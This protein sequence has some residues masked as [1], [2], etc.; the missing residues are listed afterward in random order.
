MRKRY[1]HS[2]FPICSHLSIKRGIYH[3]RRILPV[4]NT[5]LTISL[6]TSNYRDARYT[7]SVLDRKY[8]RILQTHVHMAD[9][10]AILRDQLKQALQDDLD[11]HLRTRPGRTVYARLSPPADDD[12]EPW[13]IDL[14]VIDS[15]LDTTR[16]M[17]VTRDTRAVAALA[18]DLVQRHNI[19]KEQH[20]AL[21]LGLLQVQ[22][23][24]LEAGRHRLLNGAVEPIALE[25]SIA[26]VSAST[27][28][29]ATGPLLSEAWAE[30]VA[31]KLRGAN[32]WQGHTEGQKTKHPLPYSSHTAVI[33]R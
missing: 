22:V 7:A 25:D 1:V 18:A 28:A 31:L 15:V 3:Y 17:L 16:D 26:P 29:L 21:A 5:E 10:K 27:A 4:G 13:A 20:N 2:P 14:D 33:V 30:F 11:Q 6:R 23:Q 32:P 9:L 24:M 8:T 19:P 12:R